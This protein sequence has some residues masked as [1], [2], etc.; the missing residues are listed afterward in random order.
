MD[1][2][3]VESR[4]RKWAIFL[5]AY[6]L[7]VILWGAWV[8]I[9]HSGD[10]CGDTWPL[11]NGVLI[12]EAARGKTWVEYGHR[13]TSGLY[14][15]VV[16]FLFFWSRK[17]KSKW[18]V[19]AAARWAMWTLV[20]MISEAALGAKLVLFGLV[21]SD[22]SVWRLIVMSLH[23]L[24]SFLLVA[25]TV[26]FLAATYETDY[27]AHWVYRKAEKTTSGFF[28]RPIFLAC[29]LL[30]GITGAWAAL[31]TTLFPSSNLLEGLLKDFDS[32][33]HVVLKIRGF[34]PAL[35]LLLGGGL[36][37][38]LYKLSGQVNEF[39]SRIAIA[40]S[41]LTATAMIV[42]LLTLFLLSPVPLKVIHLLL[43]HLLWSAS[44][45]FYHFHRMTQHEGFG[46]GMRNGDKVNV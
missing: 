23:Q 21:S 34:H 7:L 10:G 31:S 24:N 15:L 14:G 2:K 39:L 5:L 30:I 45:F 41:A 36:S 8:R 37:F 32:S 38:G 16:I 19:A 33:S 42:G 13:F 35:G 28:V 9:S 46:K 1:L 43:A 22:Q 4:L 6:T 18:P 40:A 11:C 29:F 12:P 3:T 25:F 44:V 20:F 17:L 26:R 27:K